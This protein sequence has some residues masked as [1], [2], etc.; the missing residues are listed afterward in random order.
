MKKKTFP[1]GNE[2]SRHAD[3]I[4][5]R[6][7]SELKSASE[8][9]SKNIA[10]QL[11][12]LADLYSSSEAIAVAEIGPRYSV[13]DHGSIQEL[14][15]RMEIRTSSSGDLSCLN[16]KIFRLEGVPRNAYP[17]RFLERLARLNDLRTT[18]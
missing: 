7:S 8:R 3:A 6:I 17:S 13:V 10:H 1:A 2:A 4:L 9:I 16:Y 14:E 18:N 12:Y 15:Q 5:E 11:P